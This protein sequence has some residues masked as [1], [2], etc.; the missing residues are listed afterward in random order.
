[1]SDTP[2]AHSTTSGLAAATADLAARMAG[3]PP[4]ASPAAPTPA[5][6]APAPAAVPPAPEPAP[7]PAPVPP[8][9]EPPPAAAPPAPDIFHPPPA[10]PAPG[11]PPPAPAPPEP[12]AA[13]A[14]IVDPQ[15]RRYLEMHGGNFEAALAKALKDNNR[16]A[17]LY[18]E[19]PEAFQPGGPADPTQLPPEDDGLFR[20][21]EPIPPE[22]EPV[23]LDPAAV[24]AEVGNRVYDDP[25]ARAM[26]TAFM[27]NKA[28]IENVN[29]QTGEPSL[30][31]QITDLEGQINYETRKMQDPDMAS[32][33]L[34]KGE[35]ES[36]LMRIQQQLGL[37]QGE[38]SR[39]LY[40]NS[41]MDQQFRQ[42]QEAV[43]NQVI[44]E[45]EQQAEEQSYTQYEQQVEVDEE[46]RVLREWPTALQRVITE[47]GIPSE[48]IEDFSNDAFL[49]PM[50]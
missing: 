49:A 50:R 47:N 36:K 5:P 8:A 2:T 27:Q 7:A 10:P 11:E 40:D 33:D 41:Q 25:N 38:R 37:L 48:Q 24:Q 44:A 17:A 3:K 45:F 1:M 14:E 35:I 43:Q 4:V 19:N 16:L 23:E 28:R 34:R 26:V 21:P 39:L 22:F 9:P 29:P 46:S 20:E 13:P 12:P 6:P 31:H 32:D 42:Y 18:R 15:A 30:N